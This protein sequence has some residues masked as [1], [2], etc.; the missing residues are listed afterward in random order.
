MERNHGKS[1]STNVMRNIH[2]RKLCLNICVG[3]SGDRLTRAAKV[4][5]YLQIC[6]FTCIKILHPLL[7][8]FPQVLEQLTGQPPVFSKA[9]YTVRSFGIRRNEKIAVHCTVRGAKAEFILEN[10]LKVCKMIWARF[11]DAET[12]LDKKKIKI[13]SGYRIWV[14]KVEF[15]R[16]RQLWIRHSGAHRSRYQIRA[17]NWHI[18]VRFLCSSW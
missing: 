8:F 1:L 3:E 18:R 4:G 10:G 2:I 9:R 17:N 14:E 13:F 5:Q 12:I 6:W 7:G 11:A 16:N 15:L